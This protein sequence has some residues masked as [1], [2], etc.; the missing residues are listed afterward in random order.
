MAENS[1]FHFFPYL[2]VELQDE[3][4]SFAAASAIHSIASTSE[5]CIVTPLAVVNDHW[6]P[7]PS[8][9]LFTVDTAWPSLAHVCRNSRDALFR[10]S[11]FTMRQHTPSQLSE[12]GRDKD[13]TPTTSNSAKDKEMLVPFRLFN[14]EIDTLYWTAYQQPVMIEF[15]RSW[16]MN[17]G[18]D[19]SIRSIAVDVGTTDTGF[20]G[21]LVELL[22]EHAPFITNLTMV[23]PKGSLRAG[24]VAQFYDETFCGIPAIRRCRIRH[25]TRSERVKMKIWGY[26][27]KEVFTFEDHLSRQKRLLEEYV[28]HGGY[29]VMTPGP[30]VA[31]LIKSATETV[32]PTWNESAEQFDGLEIHM[33]VFEEWAGT[34]TSTVGEQQWVEP[35]AIKKGDYSRLRV[36]PPAEQ[37][38]P[39]KYRPLDDEVM[40]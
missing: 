22:V 30:P 35:S 13:G 36:I 27:V 39:F 17:E 37:R 26:D 28:T 19:T 7:V 6:L 3:I 11:G 40:D 10:S 31:P 16:E 2:P 20:L 12:N 21:G 24:G 4:W 1:I 29:M 25:L 32:K 33:G 9:V 14:P 5:V 8:F 15:F 18:P 34:A 23:L 38:D